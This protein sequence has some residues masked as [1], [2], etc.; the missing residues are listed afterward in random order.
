MNARFATLCNNAKNANII[1]MTVAVDLNSSK[2][3]EK[4]QMELLKTCSSDS[5]VRLDGGKPAKLF[6]NT[7]GGELAE[8]FRQIGDELSN[9][10][11]A[12]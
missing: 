7:T 11:I 5:R 3:D 1:I 9:L 8:T 6:W 2:T 10:R 12:G 4:A